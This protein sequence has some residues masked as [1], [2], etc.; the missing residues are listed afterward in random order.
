MNDLGTQTAPILYQ[1]ISGDFDAQ[2]TVEAAPQKAYQL[3][4]IGIRSKNDPKKWIRIAIQSNGEPS[5]RVTIGSGSNLAGQF[6]Q[7]NPTFNV[8][9]IDFKISRR[10]GRLSFFHRQDKSAEWHRMVGP[11]EN[12]LPDGN[13]DDE[14]E[15]F[16]NVL[17]AHSSE[18]LD[19]K[20]L[21]LSLA[22]PPS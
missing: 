21:A 1:S 14:A 9:S 19:A 20:F 22:T 7:T 11:D 4:G 3:A 5:R 12:H 18:G 16:L 8:S 17:A 10:M 15:L 2:V 13:I 6:T